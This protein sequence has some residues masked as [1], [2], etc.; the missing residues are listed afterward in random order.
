MRKV[1][2]RIRPNSRRT[3]GEMG[4]RFVKSWKTGGVQ[5]DLLQFESPSALFRV[6]SPKRWELIGQA[7]KL[8]PCSVRGLARNLGRDVKRVHEDVVRL[9]EYGLIERR[10]DGKYFVPYDVIHADF[11]L[12]AVA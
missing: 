4:A 10:E 9:M 8:G 6:L 1:D 11:D 3:L 2:I 7:Q 12:H 5:G